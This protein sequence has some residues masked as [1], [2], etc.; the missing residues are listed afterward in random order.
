MAG[1]GN[2]MQADATPRARESV[3]GEWMGDASRDAFDRIVVEHQRRIHRI[4]L[5]FLHDAEAADTLTQECFLRAFEGRSSFRG[6]AS[7]GTWLVQIALN[8][9]RDHARS[10]RLAFWRLLTREG[11]GGDP[12]AIAGH[13][14]DPGP[15]P[16]RTVIA[17][18]RLAAVWARVDRLPRRQRT[19][20]FLRFVE[21][22][23]LAKIAQVMDLEVGTV[24]SHLAR[25]V[26]ALRRQ[27][28]AWDGPCEDT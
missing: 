25:A 6:E 10:R 20:F 12:A 22:M 27:L 11:R 21:G 16:D 28:K 2:V 19:C 23:P 1:E 4:L 9:A 3:P 14:S 26:G 5:V 13:L 24:K 7:V 8:L 17:R 15:L 18:E